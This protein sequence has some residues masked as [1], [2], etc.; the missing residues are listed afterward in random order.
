[1]AGTV[2]HKWDYPNPKM[3]QLPQDT[4]DFAGLEITPTNIRPSAKFL[5]SICNFPV[6]KDVIG[7]RVWFGL[8]N[9]DAYAFAMARQT[10]PFR[11]LLKPCSVFAWTDELD[12][13][14]H[15]SKQIIID[16]MKDEVCFFDPPPVNMPGHRLVS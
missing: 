9:Q 6:L 3:L 7:A 14:F 10:R 11:N 2:R 12:A 5:D 16:A 13:L 8:I 1:M 4:M 15:E